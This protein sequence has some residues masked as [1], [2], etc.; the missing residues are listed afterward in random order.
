MGTGASLGWPLLAGHGIVAPIVLPLLLGSL[1]VLLEKARSRWVGPLSLLGTLALLIIAAVS[2]VLGMGGASLTGY[3]I[4]SIFGVP[5]LQLD[6]VTRRVPNGCSS[7]WSRPRRCVPRR[8][9]VRRMRW[10]PR[11]GRRRPSP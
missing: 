9:S 1:L 10:A 4:V 5:A 3:F 2:I 6:G 11:T 8:I 7:G